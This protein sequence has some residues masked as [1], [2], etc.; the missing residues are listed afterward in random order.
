M[1]HSFYS[2]DRTTHAKIVALALVAGTMVAGTA[3]A[4]RCND[5][6]GEDRAQHLTVSKAGNPAIVASRIEV[7]IR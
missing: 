5:G 2:V 1:N 7:A 4:V 6:N 3:I